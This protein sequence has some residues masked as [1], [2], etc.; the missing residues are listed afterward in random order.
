M[1]ERNGENALGLW[2]AVALALV[3]ALAF[4]FSIKATQ[5]HF[6]YTT[7]IASALLRG[8]VGL[9]EQPPSWLNEMVPRGGSYYSVFPL[10]AV[11]SVMPVALLQRAA[12]VKNFPG[13]ALATLLVGL[14]TY[15]FFRLSILEGK[16]LCAFLK[17]SSKC[18]S[19]INSKTHFLTH[20]PLS[21]PAF[22]LPPQPF[23]EQ[24][25]NEK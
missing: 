25:S 10:G 13:G 23:K 17:C 7:Q 21:Q 12:L 3:A 15:F 1:P 6:D 18:F 2:L 8:H 4:T 22:L 5:Q 11:L 24:P 16:S 14:S 19:G 20:P 9:R